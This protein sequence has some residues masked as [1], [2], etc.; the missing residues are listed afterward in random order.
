MVVILAFSEG[1]VRCGHNRKIVICHQ[2]KAI[3][4]ANVE[5][6]LAKVVEQV[7][8]PQFLIEW[9]LEELKGTQEHRIKQNESILTAH[10]ASYKSV[11]QKIDSLVDRQL[12]DVKVTRGYV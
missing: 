2:K 5:I 12:L 7:D 6:E 3:A 10:Q 8:I 4:E 1:R 9:C 11:V